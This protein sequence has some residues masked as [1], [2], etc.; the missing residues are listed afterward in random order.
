[1]ARAAALMIPS[2]EPE[3]MA[4]AVVIG[5][6]DQASS[7]MRPAAASG[8]TRAAQPVNVHGM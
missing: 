1:M 4:A 6:A 3:A 8:A 5:A 2:C 7:G